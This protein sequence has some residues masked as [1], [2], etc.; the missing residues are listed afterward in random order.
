MFSP[1]PKKSGNCSDIG[2]YGRQKILDPAEYHHS[3]F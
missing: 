1:D 2:N 3:A